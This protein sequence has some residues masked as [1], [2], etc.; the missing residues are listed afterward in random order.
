MQK[1]EDEISEDGSMTFKT[2]NSEPAK[3]DLGKDDYRWV[4]LTT[5]WDT[6]YFSGYS[7]ATYELQIFFQIEFLAH[8]KCPFC[9]LFTGY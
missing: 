5:R 3:F 4:K 9:S 1:L 7:F 6:P 8:N 2:E